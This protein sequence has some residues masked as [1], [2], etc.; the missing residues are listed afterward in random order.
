M[1]KKKLFPYLRKVPASVALQYVF[2][3]KDLHMSLST[4]ID[5]LKRKAGVKTPYDKLYWTWLAMENESQQ[6]NA[7][8]N[9]IITKVGE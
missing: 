1:S 6:S 3:A 5:W 2:E 4:Y 9:A 8:Q 7:E